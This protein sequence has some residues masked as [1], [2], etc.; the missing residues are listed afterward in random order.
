MALLMGLCV[1]ANAVFADDN[2]KQP[3]LAGTWY[4]SGGVE[5]GK[6]LDAFAAQADKPVPGRNI[7]VVI[8]PH[9]GYAYAGPVAAFG[10]KA[11]S[12][13]KIATVIILASSH[14]ISF[15]GAAVWARGEFRT[16]LGAVPV[17]EE[18]ARRILAAD[19]RFVERRDVYEGLADRPEN[20]VETQ[21][22]FIQRSFPS[23]KILP[24]MVGYPPEPDVLES[25]ASALTSVVGARQDVLVAV[26]VDQSHFHPDPDARRIDARG[27]DALESMDVQAF[28]NGHRDGTMEVDGF[29]VVTAAMLYAQ[30]Q[31]YVRAKVLKYATSADTTKDTGRVVGYAS[32]ILYKD[33]VPVTVSGVLSKDE[34]QALLTIARQSVEA[35]ARGGKAAEITASLPRLKAEQGAFVTLR[36]DGRLRGCIGNIIGRGPLDMTVRDM[37]ASAAARDPRFTAV[38]PDELENIDIEISVLSVPRQADNIDSIELGTHGVIVSRGDSARGVFLP[39][40]AV[41][42]GWSKEKFLSELCSQKAGLPPDCWKDPGTKLEVFTAEVF[43]ERDVKQ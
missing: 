40:V 43:G 23:A 16:P 38:T 36:K 42:T 29:H 27:L 7:G 8:S 33:R 13:Q 31:G 9:A 22:P 35:Q 14:H 1:M 41:E 30:K 6:M 11:A 21:I 20:S 3:R 39:Q 17:D 24:V 18:M 12:D 37:A 25:L 28:W 4:P 34:R 10:F 26:S 5:L 15:H 32:V 19:P 2:V